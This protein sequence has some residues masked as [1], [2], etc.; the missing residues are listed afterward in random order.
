MGGRCALAAGFWVRVPCQHP[1]AASLGHSGEVQH[2]RAA[3]HGSHAEGHG[4]GLPPAVLHLCGLRLP[5]GG[6]LVHRGPGQPAP[7]CT[8]LP[9]V[10]THLLSS[11]LFSEVGWE[12]GCPPESK[13]APNPCLHFLVPHPV[14]HQEPRSSGCSCLGVSDLGSKSHDWQGPPG[15]WLTE[16]SFGY[17]LV[18]SHVRWNEFISRI[19]WVLKVLL[20]ISFLELWFSPRSSVNKVATFLGP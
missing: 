13:T 9:Q 10:R 4:Q 8:R 6:H 18:L 16:A 17:G 12:R 2:V 11:G 1:T 20:E 15:L 3:H 19:G 5:P 7:L 14:R